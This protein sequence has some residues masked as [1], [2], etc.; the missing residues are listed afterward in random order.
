MRYEPLKFFDRSLKALP[1]EERKKAEQ[2]ILKCVDAF[3]KREVP[4]GLGLKKLTD[5]IWEIPAGLDSRIIFRRQKDLVQWA[6]A[7]THQDI[8]HYL[9]G[10]HF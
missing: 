4:V 9:K 3:E 7:G 8:H 2:S 10:Q 1:S 5:N 6:L